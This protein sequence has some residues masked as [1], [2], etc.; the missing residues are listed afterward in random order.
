MKVKS[1]FFYYFLFILIISIIL[2]ISFPSNCFAIY[3]K[4]VSKIISAFEKVQTY[5]VAISTPAAAVSIGCGFFMQKF[6]FGDEERIRTG[7]K[8]IRT[9]VLSYAFIIS[10]DLIV[11]LIETLII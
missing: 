8:L 11:S 10:L 6:S 4:M 3:P 1:K 7:K 9:S 2:I 5:I